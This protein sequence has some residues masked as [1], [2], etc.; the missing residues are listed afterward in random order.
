MVHQPA[1]IF[2]AALEVELAVS[3]AN[4]S[5]EYV[6]SAAPPASKRAIRDLQRQ[7]LQQ[8]DM[9]VLGPEGVMCAICRWDGILTL[10]L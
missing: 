2:C 1:A 10:L 6:P 5:G 4:A 3:L 7:V 8:S 9:A